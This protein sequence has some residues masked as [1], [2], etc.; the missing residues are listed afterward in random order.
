MDI[1]GLS[2]RIDLYPAP[3]GG[4]HI[5]LDTEYSH[6]GRIPKQTVNPF[7]QFYLGEFQMIAET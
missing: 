1:Y 4:M 3:F 6:A 7:S 2:G 5:T